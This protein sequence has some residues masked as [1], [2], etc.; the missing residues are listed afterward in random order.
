VWAVVGWLVH[1]ESQIL[2]RM[3]CG[4]WMLAGCWLSWHVPIF[5]D[6]AATLIMRTLLVA[7]LLN[8]HKA[9]ALVKIVL[10][11]F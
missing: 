5:R 10:G 1:P 4:G 6:Q 7:G 3:R 11:R 2:I 8:F 9:Q